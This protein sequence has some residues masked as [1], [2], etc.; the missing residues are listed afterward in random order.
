MEIKIFFKSI[1]H[2]PLVQV[3]RRQEI[4][5]TQSENLS[6]SSLIGLNLAKATYIS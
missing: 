1:G 3:T 2:R 6:Q 4:M 5:S